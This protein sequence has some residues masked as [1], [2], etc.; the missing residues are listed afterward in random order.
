MSHNCHEI[1]NHRQLD[2]LF[3]KLLLTTKKT[4][5][6]PFAS[7]AIYGGNYIP[8]QSDS[9]VKSDSI[10]CRHHDVQYIINCSHASLTP[11]VLSWFGAGAHFPNEFSIVIQIRWKF[12]STLFEVVVK[13]SLWHFA[14]G[15]IAVLSWHVQNCIAIWYTTMSLHLNQFSIEFELWWKNCSWN[16]PQVDFTQILQ[17]YFIELTWW[18]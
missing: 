11:C 17:G 16:G 14:H 1:S 6:L 18:V 4:P 10:T 8:F 12:H 2:S 3:N 7:P 13:W 9:N 5:K 15:T